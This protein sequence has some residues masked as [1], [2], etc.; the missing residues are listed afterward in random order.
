MEMSVKPLNSTQL[1]KERL[2]QNSH[3]HQ[4]KS[5]KRERIKEQTGSNV[6]PMEK[7]QSLFATMLDKEIQLLSK[8]ES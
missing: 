7:Q 8:T 6:S 2:K 1:D 4:E 3:S 5:G